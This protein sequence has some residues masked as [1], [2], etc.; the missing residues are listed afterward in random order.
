MKLP[1]QLEELRDQKIWLNYI[2]IYNPKKHGGAGGYDK[3]PVNPHTLRDGSSRDPGRW[4]TFDECNAQIGQP[5]T[6][7]YKNKECIT[8]PVAGVGI[9]LEAAGILG[10][11]FD[12]VIKLDDRGKITAIS[13]EAQSIWQSVNSY[14]EISVSGTGVHIL[15]YG[16]KPGKE[17][18]R[19]HNNDGTDY[20]MYDSGRYFTLSGKALKG[21]G[22]ICHRYEQ[23]KA[24]YDLILKR[25]AGSPLSV[26]PCSGGGGQR[27]IPA[28]SDRDLWERMFESKN[29]Q[30]IRA[31]FDGDISNCGNDRSRADLAL[32]NSLAYWTNND[33]ERIDR[34]FR[35]SG[36]MREKWNRADYRNR[37]I[38]A[39]ID[40]T[41]T[42]CGYT[43]A[44]KKK[45]AQQKEREEFD[46][47]LR[48]A[49]K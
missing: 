43:A 48:R 14:T 33:K 15:V 6:V 40:K 32:C 41:S 38:Q 37:T 44:E 20:E 17:V 46:E 27:I 49:E 9:V 36:L 4:G 31:L 16:K 30:K 34:M 39:A 29:G 1:E 12:N 8:Q 26:D 35:Q 25:R 18:C 7:F 22:K 11:D 28:E 21:C 23:V 19:I 5:A 10:I 2:L 24:V 42:Y 45:Y 13:K 3:P 47:I